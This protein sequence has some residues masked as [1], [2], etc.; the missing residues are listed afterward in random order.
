[1]AIRG[2]ALLTALAL[3]GGVSA[4]QVT[5]N[6]PCASLCIDTPDL[7][8]SDPNSSNTRNSDM[9]CNDRLY[10]ASAAGIKWK[11][12]MSC[13]QTSTYN[14]GKESDQAWFL[15]KWHTLRAARGRFVLT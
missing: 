15:C 10:K 13:L 12:C 2:L 8:I 5:P 7:D 4:L 9:T 11:S 3:S 1:M 14:Q 6:S